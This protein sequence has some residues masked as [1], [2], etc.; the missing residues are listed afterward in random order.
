MKQPRAVDVPPGVY[1]IRWTSG[2]RAVGAIGYD[3]TGRP[4]FA[5]C[6]WVAGIPCYEW[7]RIKE[8]KPITLQDLFGQQ[9]ESDLG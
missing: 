5:P 1:V 2:G 4:W 8:V 6:N 7:R 3:H 9:D